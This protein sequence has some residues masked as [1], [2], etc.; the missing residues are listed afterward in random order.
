MKV[1]LA[2]LGTNPQTVN[3]VKYSIYTNR[4]LAVSKGN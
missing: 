3:L 1:T 2:N 4:G